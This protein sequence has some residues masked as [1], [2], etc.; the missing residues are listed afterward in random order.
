MM[1]MKF[2]QPPVPQH[3]LFSTPLTAAPEGGKLLCES[4][5]RTLL[6]PLSAG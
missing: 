6:Y 3:L 1:L 5:D 4:S 2:P